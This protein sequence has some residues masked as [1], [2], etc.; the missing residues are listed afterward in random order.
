MQDAD[1]QIINSLIDNVL[2]N[3][4]Q[5]IEETLNSLEPLS[6]MRD[7]ETLSRLSVVYST[8]LGCRQNKEKGLSLLIRSAELGNA[9]AALNLA[10]HYISKIQASKRLQADMIRRMGADMAQGRGPA[11]L[12]DLGLQLSPED[13]E[14]AAKWYWIAKSRGAPIP[15]D[16][17]FSE[18]DPDVPRSTYRASYMQP[19]VRLF[20]ER[21]Y[22]A[23]YRFFQRYAARED[24][25]AEI[26]IATLLRY[27][28]GVM[29]NEA[30]ALVLYKKAVEHQNGE[31]AY[32]LSDI[33]ANGYCGVEIDLEASG[34]WMERAKEL[35]FISRNTGLFGD[36]EAP[37][38]NGGYCIIP[39]R[40]D[41]TLT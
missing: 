9:D 15:N 6:E 20:Y 32:I 34:Y 8:G 3:P 40:N 18:I 7:P 36:S 30:D 13:I 28:L 38:E 41:E 37:E 16:G 12:R 19:G 31:A 27:G 29:R 23:A 11:I 14:N 21:N 5:S 2:N 4:N 22:E 1:F 25:L 35:G 26:M 24:P 10:M 33:Y 39:N 17:S